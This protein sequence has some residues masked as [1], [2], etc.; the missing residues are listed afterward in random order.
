MLE[1]FQIFDK[2]LLILYILD[3][4][5]KHLSI[6]QLTTLCSDIG[7][8][9]YFDV[10]EYIEILKNNNFIDVELADET[11]L[12][13]LTEKGYKTLKELIELIPGLD[14]YKLKKM[15]SDS[16]V[17][18]KQE[19][20]IGTS[21]TPLKNG[22]YRVNCYIKDDNEEIFNIMLFAGNKENAKTISK[23]W[24]ENNEN[25]HSKILGMLTEE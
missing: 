22:Q 10:C 24:Q 7:N 25:I 18:I 16:I 20:E 1:N 15:I 6:D 4:T 12:Y 8:I 19:Y 17:G 2:K 9:T 5:N 13:F 14:L 11:E 23:N 21:L 3:T